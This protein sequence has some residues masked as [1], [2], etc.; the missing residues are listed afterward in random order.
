[1]AGGMGPGMGPGMMGPGMMGPG[2]GGPRVQ[3]EVQLRD[4]SWAGFDTALPETPEA[5]PADGGM[6]SP[7]FSKW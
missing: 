2:M 4:G 7:Q 1:M 6:R 5:L 3:I